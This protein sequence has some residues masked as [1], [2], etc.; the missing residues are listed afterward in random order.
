M[1]VGQTLFPEVDP[2]ARHILSWNIFYLFRL[3]KKCK[4]SL[5]GENWAPN[6]VK[7]P[8]LGLARHWNANFDGDEA[9]PSIIPAGRGHLVK[10][11]ITFELH[12]IF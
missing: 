5:T 12:G 2:F 7:L 6:T 11:F 3:F 4:L 1:F 10:M 9:S 8:P